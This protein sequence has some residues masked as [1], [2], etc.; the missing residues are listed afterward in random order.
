MQT[1]NAADVARLDRAYSTPQIVDQR[2][3]FR[4]A[5]AA[6]PGEVGLDVGCGA[7]HLA[8]ELAREVMPGGRIV[9][10]DKSPQSVEASRARAANEELAD[11]IDVRIGD[12]TALEFPDATFDFVVAVQVYSFVPNVARAIKEAARVLRKGGRLLV[13]ES[14]WDMCIWKSKDPAFTRRMISARAETQF[15]HAYLPRDLH[16]YLRSAG[17]TL[18]DV[19]AFSIVE[20]HYDPES[21]GASV[22]GITRD[23]ALKHGM[24]AG[25]VAAWEEDLRSRTTEGEWFFCLDRF[26]FMATK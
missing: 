26:V 7:G 12:A 19:Q 17:L 24:P 22:I 10:I 20:T 1:F 13:L 8:C 11:V 9:A 3:R 14:D 4:A 18:A 15:A 2:R 25:D 6:R 16:K 5:V 21:Y 23:S